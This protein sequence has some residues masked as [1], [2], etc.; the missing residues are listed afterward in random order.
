MSAE[1]M[2]ELRGKAVARVSSKLDLDEAQRAKLNVLADTLE[3]QRKLLAG[4]GAGPRSELTSLL[5]SDRFDRTRAQVL[6][7]EKT[8]SVQ[9]MGPEV[10]NAMADFFDSLNPQQQQKVRERLQGRHGS[11]MSRG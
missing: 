5:A 7:D 10:I 9:T 6:L 2:S 3:A 1:K 11:W 8:R 4:A